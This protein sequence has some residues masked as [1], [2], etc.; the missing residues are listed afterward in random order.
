[1]P[2][3]RIKID[4]HGVQKELGQPTSKQ[5]SE[6]DNTFVYL[7]ELGEYTIAFEA[8][9]ENSNVITILLYEN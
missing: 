3:N 9:N 7:Y 8:H 1:M 5:Y 2:G 4:L 6:L